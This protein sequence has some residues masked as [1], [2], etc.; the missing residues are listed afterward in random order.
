MASEQ[1][2]V[3]AE[4]WGRTSSGSVFCADSSLRFIYESHNGGC[5]APPSAAAITSLAAAAGQQHGGVIKPHQQPLQQSFFM[6][7]LKGA[8]QSYY[9]G[10]PGGSVY[11]VPTPEDKN[12]GV[13][14]GKRPRESSMDA[15]SAT[16]VDGVDLY[17]AEIA[18]ACTVITKQVPSLPHSFREC[19]VCLS[20][21]AYAQISLC[22]HTFHSKCFLRWFRMN[23]S[24]PLCRGH[25]D[26]VQLAPV[27]SVQD[28]LEAIMAEIDEE[29]LDVDASK[30]FV[31]PLMENPDLI[32]FLESDFDTDMDM[33]ALDDVNPADMDA[34][35]LGHHH[36]DMDMDMEDDT[37]ALK[38]NR[39]HTFVTPKIEQQQPMMTSA[40][41]PAVAQNPF[42]A[43][44]ASASAPMQFAPSSTM[45]NYWNVLNQGLSSM[46]PVMPN[47]MMNYH[48]HSH[49]HHHQSQQ[50]MVHIAPKPDARALQ[51]QLIQ[52]TPS[53]GD[54]LNNK[55]V[56]SFQ[57]RSTTAHI[58]SPSASASS[59]PR[60]VSCRCTGGCRNGRCACVKE[61]GMCGVSCRCTS[62][63]NP[64]LMVKA[65]GADI[66]ALLKDNCF[67]H[68]VSKTRDMVQRLQEPVNVPCCNKAIKVIDC[69][70][71][72]SCSSCARG[73][74]FSWCMN[75]LLDSEK[76]P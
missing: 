47:P 32:H 23:R 54:L 76:T 44:A 28:E 52:P 7:Q 74:D 35:V 38:Q 19:S 30:S 58:A 75:K 16:R 34:H 33:M 27:V 14:P 6:D 50:R 15:A 66:D 55:S 67:M 26:K 45:P 57:Q 11:P 13:F 70:Q 3:V 63:K 29:P 10:V 42:L 41:A 2:R 17:E 18:R 48:A 61:G 20:A 24:C 36:D 64:F 40:A 9:G 53:T 5:A 69:V 65:A 59:T 25:V 31:D 60:V 49:H 22:G 37:P 68:N 71:G 8:N 43:A 62:C 1:R 46:P 4:G 12:S 73:F 72:Y 56:P 51:N 39:A 21:N